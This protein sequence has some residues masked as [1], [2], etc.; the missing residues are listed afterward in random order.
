LL[1]G[2]SKT[3]KAGSGSLLSFLSHYF[4]QSLDDISIQDASIP[5]EASLPKLQRNKSLSTLSN[6]GGG[7]ITQSKNLPS[8][9]DLIYQSGLGSIVHYFLEHS[10]FEPS[11]KSIDARFREFGLPPKLIHSYSKTASLLLLNTKRDKDFEWLF[12]YR[13][14]TEVEAE[15]SSST[16]TVIIDRLFIEDD[17]LWIID[18]KTASL[19][20]GES[21]DSFIERQKLS[22][23]KQIKTYQE[24]LED[25]FKIPS[26]IALYCPAVSKLI[27]L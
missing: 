9:V 23:Q 6:R 16:K 20:E 7:D 12:K 18:F 4:Q 2:V 1:G 3:G 15:Y 25:F 21:M 5:V 14:S 24:V 19:N 13:D 8:N 26:K 11:F 17:S 10:L 22:H 27:L